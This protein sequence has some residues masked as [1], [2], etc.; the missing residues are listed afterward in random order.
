M[1]DPNLYQPLLDQLA[2]HDR[3]H[4]EK[5]SG[6][7]LS[8]YAAADFYVGPSLEDAFNLPLLETMACGLPV[9]ASVQAGASENVHDFETGLLLRD[10]RIPSNS[11]SSAADCS[12]M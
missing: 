10:P 9:I 3:V 2:L 5:P 7:V 1:D 11:Y 6:G 12:T 8:F 4:F